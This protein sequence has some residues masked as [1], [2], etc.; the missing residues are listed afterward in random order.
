MSIGHEDIVASEESYQT[1]IVSLKY[2]A[3]SR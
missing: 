1:A 3:T 2:F